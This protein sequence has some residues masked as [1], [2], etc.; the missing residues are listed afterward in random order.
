MDARRFSTRQGCL[1]EKSRRRSGP[2]ARSASG[3]EAGACFSWLLLFARAKRSNSLLRSR[4][5]SSAFKLSSSR[6]C[7]GRCFGL[8]ALGF[9][10]LA[11]VSLADFLEKQIQ[12]LEQYQRLSLPFGA[13][14]T[15]LF[16]CKEKQPRETLFNSRMTGQH[17]PSRDPSGCARRSPVLLACQGGWRTTRFAQTRAPLRPLS[18]C[19]A[20]LALRPEKS[21]ARTEQEQ[22]HEQQQNFRMIALAA[23]RQASQAI[24]ILARLDPA[25]PPWPCRHVFG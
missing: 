11:L 19:G 13:R 4:G 8:W 25:T 5:E 12:M 3:A 1:V 24:H 17:G 20:R 6:S 16:S 7:I 15:S 23:S 18:R 14:A 10:I 2:G 9:A 22:D 21:E